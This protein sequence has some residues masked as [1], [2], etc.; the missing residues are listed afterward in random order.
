MGTVVF[1]HKKHY[2]IYISELISDILFY[3]RV[4]ELC[5][6]RT[7]KIIIIYLKYMKLD[8]I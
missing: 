2:D 3:V 4:H 8:F 7:I 5:G 6:V 1:Q